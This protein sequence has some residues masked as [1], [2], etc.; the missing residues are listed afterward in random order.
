MHITQIMSTTFDL[1]ALRKKL[2]MTRAALAE[3][4]GVDVST[5]CRWETKGVPDRGPAR[6]F[7]DRLAREASLI[8]EANA[9]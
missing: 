8:E 6:A 5:V 9:A 7:L 4:A 2:N 1:V 3:Q